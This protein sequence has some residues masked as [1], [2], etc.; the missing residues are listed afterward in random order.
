MLD[1]YVDD[2]R[3]GLKAAGRYT[4]PKRRATGNLNTAA[5]DT[6]LQTAF[7]KTLGTALTKAIAP[8]AINEFV[9]RYLSQPKSYV[10]FDPPEIRLTLGAFKRQAISKNANG[11]ILDLRSRLLFDDKY[12]F[13]NGETLTIANAN[14]ACFMRLANTRQ[15]DAQIVKSLSSKGFEALYAQWLRGF[16]H[17]AVE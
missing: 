16:V 1:A 10:T 7:A 5:I 4:D 9:G 6:P 2:L 13:M 12:F 17:I 11:I 15:L 8:A 3:D 14:R